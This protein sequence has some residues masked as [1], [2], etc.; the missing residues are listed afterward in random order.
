VDHPQRDIVTG[1]NG[2][3]GKYLTRKLLSLGH[4]VST[5]TGHPERKHEFGNLV[6]VYPFDFDKPELLA[7]HLTDASTVYNTY[8]VRFPYGNIDY[9]QAVKNTK[10][11]IDAAKS[12]GVK[13]FVHTSIANSDIDS[14]LPYYKQKAVLEKY[15]MESGLNYAIIGP[16]VIFGLEDILIN[17]IA[18]MLR[19][20]PVFG[21][22]GSGD[23]QIQPIY[24]EDMT[25][26]AIE[27]ASR[28]ENIVVD[29][30]GPEI[31]S[32]KELVRLIADTIGSKSKLVSLPAPIA[33]KITKSIGH[34]VNDVIITQEE[35]EGLLG[36]LL[37]SKRPATG[38]T[39][40]SQWL[41]QNRDKVGRKY[42]S[43]LKRHFLK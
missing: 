28:S 43:E 40:F 13:K 24:V 4:N 2:Y 18:W 34:F 17:N 5:L 36:N 42:S 12:A 22:I 3:T 7:K 11:L 37:V 6:P 23:Y 19:T 38:K 9:S 32:F 41:S 31:F 21:I 30:V 29:A 39:S 14:A 10:V 16:T 27:A 33:L 25:N 15:L 8:W 26:L 20:F 35:V 1:A